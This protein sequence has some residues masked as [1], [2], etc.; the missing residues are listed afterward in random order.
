MFDKQKHIDEL[1]H[2]I[3]SG[4]VPSSTVYMDGSHNPR[5][6]ETMKATVFIDDFL[7]E[8]LTEKKELIDLLEEAINTIE[9]LVDQQAM[10]DNWYEPIFEKIKNKLK[11]LNNGL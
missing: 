11:E 5:P 7:N 8:V 4:R 2:L 9:G 3:A 6:S 10:P 1:S